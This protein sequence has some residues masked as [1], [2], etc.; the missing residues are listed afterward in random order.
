MK[1]SFAILLLFACSLSMFGQVE[2]VLVKGT[3]SY[4]SSQNVYVKYASTDGISKGDTLFSQKGNVL[5]PYLVVRDKSTTSCVCISL[6]TEKVAVGAEFY[7]RVPKKE[8]PKKQENEKKGDKSRPA[9]DSL[10]PAVTNPVVVTPETEEKTGTRFQAKNKGACVGFVV[11]Q[12]GRG[13]GNPPYALRLHL[14]GQQPRQLPL[15][16]GQLHH[17]PAHGG[18]VAGGEGQF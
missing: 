6:L 11:Q 8:A 4:V 1:Y 3:A 5:T 16:D 15:F 14:A 7:A 9:Q 2:T 18:R 17:L 12:L 10:L 13:R